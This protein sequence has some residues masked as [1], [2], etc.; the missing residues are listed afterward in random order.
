M[1]LPDMT[2]QWLASAWQAGAWRGWLSDRGSL[3]Q[4]LR[5]RC[6]GLRVI[7]L[8][9][10]HGLPD[11]DERRPLRLPRGHL[12]LLREVL[13]TC[14]DTPLVFAHSV[15]PLAGLRGPWVGLSRLGHSPLGAALFANPRIRRHPLQFRRVDA[16][17]PLYQGAARHLAEPST[18]LWARRS[19]FVLD[20]R[21]IL[22][23]EVFLPPIL[24]LPCPHRR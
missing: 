2:T 8:R 12:A 19:L 4:R 3:T 1:T 23:T 5:E 7:R 13:L 21:P 16:R 20:R 9:Q 10:A 14:G 15:I 18:T 6:P 22:V 11:E 24:D 17:H